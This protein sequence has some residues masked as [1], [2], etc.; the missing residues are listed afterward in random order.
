MWVQCKTH[1]PRCL[2]FQGH[3]AE[4]L[5]KNCRQAVFGTVL[6]MWGGPGLDESRLGITRPQ[7]TQVAK[8]KC[9]PVGPDG[10]LATMYAV[11]GQHR[12]PREVE[13]RR[14]GHLNSWLKSGAEVWVWFRVG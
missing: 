12:P 2:D 5:F 11:E 9:R 4:W 8:A 3:E 13:H 7:E 1:S 6:V 10:Y 14:Q